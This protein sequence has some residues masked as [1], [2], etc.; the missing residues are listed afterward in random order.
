VTGRR[1]TEDGRRTTA[2]EKQRRRTEPMAQ[3][4]ES[5]RDL[6]VYKLAMELQQEVF[7]LSKSFPRPERNSIL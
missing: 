1:K 3:R 2:N 6:N 5:F 4:I 7:F